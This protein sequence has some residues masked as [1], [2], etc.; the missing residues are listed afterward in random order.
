MKLP[1]SRTN[2]TQQIIIL[3]VRMVSLVSERLTKKKSSENRFKLETRYQNEQRLNDP[4]KQHHEN[5]FIGDLE[6]EAE[7]KNLP[8]FY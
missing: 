3:S 2:L 6:W 5:R 8:W 7:D 4:F 1:C